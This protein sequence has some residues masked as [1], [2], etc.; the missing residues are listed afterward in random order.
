[1]HVHFIEPRPDGHRMQYVRRLI[2]QAPSD[3]TLS[4]STFPS[5]LMHPGT[6][7]AID[8]GV[9]RVQ[10]LSIQG[11]ARFERLTL[12]CDGFKLQPAYW[13]LLRAHWR[14]LRPTQRGDLVV[15][16]YLDYVSYAVGLFGS[17]F[18]QTLFSGI[19]M[20]PDFHWAEQGVMAPLARH[21]A[22]KRWLFLRL[23]RH[24]R[25]RCLLSIDPSLRD[26]VAVQRPV[27]HD[28]LL[29][30]DDPADLNGMGSCNEARAFFG[31]RPDATVILM[32]G[33]IDLRKG[34]AA[35]LDIARSSDFP[36][37][38]QV[39][40]VGRQSADVRA[41]VVERARSLPHGRLVAVDRYVSR[42]EEWLAYRAADLG[43]VAYED[44]YGPSGVVSQC[45]QMGLPMVH[46]GH[47]LIGY[48]LRAAQ[49]VSIPWLQSKGLQV[50][51]MLTTAPPSAGLQQVMYP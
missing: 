31:L 8:A 5:A 44:F 14:S 18:G 17:P 39:L 10:V 43:W 50:A 13:R 1:M 35:L 20:R 25:L 2:E 12:G 48:Q 47:G 51:R 4:L 38:T 32:F 24:P 23:L 3:W 9:G 45:R 49:Q 6:R 7:S 41:L 28:R 27:G 46:R 42:Q 40:M 33:S 11:E 30:A 29:Y 34:V 26:W 36:S 37:N 15:V 16:P 21:G 19:V 22:L